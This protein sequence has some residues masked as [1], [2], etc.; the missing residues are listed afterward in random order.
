VG[1]ETTLALGVKGDG[2]PRN[3]VGGLRRACPHHARRFGPAALEPR[4]KN[5]PAATATA[6]GVP[7]WAS[8]DP[9]G[10]QG[11]LNL[12]GATADNPLNRLDDLGLE[13]EYIPPQRERVPRPQRPPTPA[14]PRNPSA[15][16]VFPMRKPFTPGPLYGET[17]YV[18]PPV[19]MKGHNLCREMA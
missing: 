14:V 4:R 10:E 5:R 3:R 8:R 17:H 9:I 6:S 13:V 19:S 18:D 15:P 2:P 16:P 1:L 12:Y 11:G 7:L